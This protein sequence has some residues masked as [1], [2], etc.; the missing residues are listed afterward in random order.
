MNFDELVLGWQH[1]EHGHGLYHGSIQ[2]RLYCNEE[3]FFQIPP[4][5]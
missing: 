2:L 1:T 3:L 5:A 4:L